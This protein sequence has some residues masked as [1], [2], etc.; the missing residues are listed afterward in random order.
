[1]A[2]HPLVSV[3]VPCYNYAAYMAQTIESVLAQDYPNIEVILI[4]D[5][6]TDA[7][8]D[9]ARRYPQ[10]TYYYQENQG[11][12]AARNNG[13]QKIHGEYVIFLDADDKLAPGFVAKTVATA[14]QHP[15][16]G[17][18]YTQQQYFEAADDITEFPDYDVALLKKKNYIP[19]CT[20]IR[21]AVLRKCT[22][23]TRFK[24]WEDWDFY[25]SLAERGIYGVRLN[26]PLILYRKHADQASMLD[27]F[28]EK[29]K[30]R[31]LALLRYKHWRLYGA[32]E[33]FRFTLWYLRNR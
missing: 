19:A 22:Y 5:G 10:A 16:A 6:S 8:A 14:Q 20:L 1:M 33:T 13:F 4:D 28:S 11:L 27:T 26:E 7:T 32:A 21:T 25:L 30:V 23:D 31:T 2:R 17:F 24:S 12:S 15:D 18:V 9:I 3:V 29:K